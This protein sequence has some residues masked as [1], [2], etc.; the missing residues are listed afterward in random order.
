[1]K[2]KTKEQIKAVASVLYNMGKNGTGTENAIDTLTESVE[3]W[4]KQ[5][6]KE[7]YRKAKINYDTIR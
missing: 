6:K 1:M 4:T 7:G 2:K 5:A 3:I